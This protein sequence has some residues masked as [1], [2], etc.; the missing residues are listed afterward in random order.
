M[1]L[2]TK[3]NTVRLSHKR[4]GGWLNHISNKSIQNRLSRRDKDKQNSSAESQA[5]DTLSYEIR[6]QIGRLAIRQKNK[7]RIAQLEKENNL[8]IRYNEILQQHSF[9]SFNQHRLTY[10]NIKKF[11]NENLTQSKIKKQTIRTFRKKYYYTKDTWNW[12]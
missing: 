8:N 4:I 12:Y 1:K 3:E 2:Q 6:Y 7:R 11:E 9:P 10:N 5:T